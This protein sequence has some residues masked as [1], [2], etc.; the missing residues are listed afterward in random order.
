MTS[1]T[2]D[3]VGLL[4]W[5][6]LLY[7]VSTCVVVTEPSV[8]SDLLVPLITR[9]DQTIPSLTQ[10]L[11]AGWGV[12]GGGRGLILY[13][14]QPW[15]ALYYQT[16]PQSVR[17]CPF[18][19]FKPSE[20]ESLCSGN[21][22]SSC[23]ISLFLFFFKFCFVPSSHRFAVRNAHFVCFLDNVGQSAKKTKTKP[24]C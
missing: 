11:W 3:Q 7:N 6:F 21:L 10:L 8:L 20:G 5:G 14:L 24:Q 18:F 1:C 17:Q 2:R 23:C 15:E 12:E 9:G 19:S 16:L 4:F 13:I 22:W